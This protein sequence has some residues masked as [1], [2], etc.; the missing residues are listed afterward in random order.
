MP[1]KGI[2]CGQASAKM[3]INTEDIL[4]MTNCPTI[5]TGMSH[6]MRTH[7]NSIVAFAFLLNNS[8]SN[9]TDKKQFSNHILSSCE[10]LMFLF[11]NF[12]DSAI[13]DTGSSKSEPRSCNLGN[14]IDDLLS[15]FRVI[16]KKED[17]REVVLV[18]EN[19]QQGG[20]EVIMDSNSVSR[21]IRSLFLNALYNTSSGYIKIGYF[22]RESSVTFYVLDSG[23]GYSKCVEFLNSNDINASLLKYNDT[24][25]ALTIILAR[26]LINM[27]GG[28]IWVENNGSSGCGFFIS[29]PVKITET[30]NVPIDKY[31]KNNPRVAI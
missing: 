18:L 22:I 11:D 15:E 12:L 24:P 23:D 7:M 5:L 8:D 29:V 17:H 14:V 16:L 30:P 31:T 10:Q 6:E 27:M 9:E 4:K 25:S 2:N 28:K 1:D 3:K 13:I 20:A 21:V 19:H 26:K